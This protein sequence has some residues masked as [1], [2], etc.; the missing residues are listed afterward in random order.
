MFVDLARNIDAVPVLITQARLVSPK[1]STAEKSKIGYDYPKMDHQ[2]LVQAFEKTDEI[3]KSVAKTK[4]VR[5]IDASAEMTGVNEYFTDHVHLSKTGSGELARI[6]SD[7]LFNLI[8]D[9][10][11]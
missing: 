8:N 11:K 2:T 1:N 3:I 9:S 10:Q 7:Y 5:L 6:V 4:R